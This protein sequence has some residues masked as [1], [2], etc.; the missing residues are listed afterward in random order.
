MLLIAKNRDDFLLHDV[1]DI[2]FS[3]FKD[4]VLTEVFCI[5]QGFEFDF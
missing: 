3:K 2:R 5:Y 1:Y 4:A